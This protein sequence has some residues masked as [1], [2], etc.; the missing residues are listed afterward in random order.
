MTFC[1]KSYEKHI[2]QGITGNLIRSVKRV[3][4][5]QGLLPHSNQIRPEK[6]TS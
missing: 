2:D 6:K 5:H 1:K 3:S 4:D